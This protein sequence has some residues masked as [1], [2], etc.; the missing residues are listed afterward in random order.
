MEIGTD[1]KQIIEWVGQALDV[2]GVGII[3]IGMAYGALQYA[4]E[5]SRGKAGDGYAA[6]RLY[7]V[8]ALLLGLEVLVAADVIRTVA[9]SPTLNSVA[10]LAAIVAIRTFL[11]WS[12]ILELEGRWPWQKSGTNPV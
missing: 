10:V 11:S 2:F 12:L 9:V 3:A 1:L 8:R 5:L 4:L 6:F 7:L